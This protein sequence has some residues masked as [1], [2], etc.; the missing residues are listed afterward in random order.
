MV[1]ATVDGDMFETIQI[2]DEDS[3]AYGIIKQQLRN[4]LQGDDIEYVYTMRKVGNEL[5]FV[6]D[7]DIDDPALI[8]DSYQSYDEIEQA[9]A[10]NVVADSEVTTDEW[11]RFYSGFAPIYNSN[12]TVVGIVGVDCSVAFIDSESSA[13]LRNVIIIECVGLVVSLIFALFISG[14]LAKNV[15]VIDKKVE[16]LANSK[17]DLTKEISVHT[18]DEVGSI[19]SSMNQF[20]K[21]LRNM[22]LE[23]KGDEQKLMENSDII[24]KSMKHSVDEIQGMSAAMQQTAAS[25][26]DM[27]EK[28]RNIK[29]EADSSGDLAKA[30]IKETAENVQHTVQ[31]QENARNFQNDAIDAKN[32]MQLHVNDIGSGLEEKIKQSQRVERIGE[33]TGKIVEIANQTNLLSLNASIEAARAG[34]SGRGFAVVASEIGNLAEQSA[35]TAKEISDINQEIIQMVKE[36]SESAFQLL[37]IVN[38]QVMKDYDMLE[39]TGESYYQDAALFRNQMESCMDYMKQLQASMDTIKDKVT[40]IASGLQ[41]ETDVVQ[42]NSESIMGLQK[43]I[44]A[45]DDS[46]E[47]NEKIVQSLD[48]ILMGFRL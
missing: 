1:A 17:G 11:G 2:G 39:Q 21:S 18:K 23:I 5:Q 36:L 16:E 14:I 25:M 28:V 27:Y 44:K 48:N 29:E 43:Q 42:D 41:V 45:V 37:N 15:M 47:E 13:M 40:D 20:L 38:T 46:V 32:K 33:L 12:G 7:A 35:G 6:V 30:I 34:E 10:G 19:A 26:Q 3:V 8:G 31:I 9:F 22:L 24:D 4:F